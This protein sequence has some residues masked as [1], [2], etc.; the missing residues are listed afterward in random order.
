MK[1]FQVKGIGLQDKKR[2]VF[3]IKYRKRMNFD[4]FSKVTIKLSEK[5]FA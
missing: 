1:P 5:N 4:P 3:E 2:Y